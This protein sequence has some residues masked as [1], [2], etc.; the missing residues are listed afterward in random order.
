MLVYAILYIL[1]HRAFYLLNQSRIRQYN[2]LSVLGI[3]FL[4]AI[5]DEF[6]QSLVPGRHPAMRDIGFDMLGSLVAFLRLYQ[7]I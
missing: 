1:M 5:S 3:C 2:W 4:F 7:Y 6:H